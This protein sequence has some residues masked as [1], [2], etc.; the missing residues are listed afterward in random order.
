MPVAGACP[1]GLDRKKLA[2]FSAATGRF[3]GLL[4]ALASM[5]D[6]QNTLMTRDRAVDDLRGNDRLATTR[7]GY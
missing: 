7:W 4:G 2:A 5:G 6:H 3:L 1:L